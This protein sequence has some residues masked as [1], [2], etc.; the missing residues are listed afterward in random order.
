LVKVFLIIQFYRLN[1]EPKEYAKM[2]VKDTSEG[3][4][5]QHV[6]GTEVWYNWHNEKGQLHRVDGPAVVINGTEIW[7]KEG[8]RHREGGLPSGEFANGSKEWFVEGKR[9]RDG[10]LPA[11]VRRNGTMFWYKHG[12]RHRVGSPATIWEDGSREWWED[13]RRHR[14]GGPAIENLK[15]GG[16]RLQVQVLYAAL[17]PPL[18]LPGYINEWWLDGVNY[19]EE[20]YILKSKRNRELGFKYFHKWYDSLDDLST[21]VGKKRMLEH[22]NKISDCLID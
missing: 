5:R 2:Y 17:S 15:V 14:I 7:Y 13:G 6:G 16:L 8:E 19:S 21:E 22:V 11:I 9:H 4:M 3:Y 12:R 10:D 18:T 20:D 1:S